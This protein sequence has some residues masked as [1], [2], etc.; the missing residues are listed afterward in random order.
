MASLST[1]I[2]NDNEEIK[3]SIPIPTDKT[4]LPINGDN[5]WENAFTYSIKYSTYTYSGTEAVV[6]NTSIITINGTI[7]DITY[8]STPTPNLVFNLGTPLKGIQY[9]SYAAITITV[10]DDA[11]GSVSFSPVNCIV[12]RSKSVSPY[13]LSSSWNEGKLICEFVLDELMT[14]LPIR[15]NIDLNYLNAMYFLPESSDPDTDIK[16]LHYVIEF[17]GIT[18][19]NGSNKKDIYFWNHNNALDTVVRN[20]NIANTTTT[21]AQKDNNDNTPD[22]ILIE[23]VSIYQGRGLHFKA[24]IKE[25]VLSNISI[26]TGGLL[27]IKMTVAY[28]QV[29]QD[30]DT[31]V[32][33]TTSINIPPDIKILYLRQRNVTAT[34]PT[35]LT[36]SDKS[37]LTVGNVFN[38][39]NITDNIALINLNAAMDN[40]IPNIGFYNT[41]QEKYFDLFIDTSENDAWYTLIHTGENIISGE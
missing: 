32:T 9:D 21:T 28:G 39:P 26:A 35:G 11:S 41:S 1:R 22:D 15:G 16:K 31:L 25:S 18:T 38:N 37:S 33:S 3:L 27:S 23:E 8:E 5:I 29:I 36:L 34:A 30:T 7:T 12:V 20:I 6:D 40:Q 17:S 24:E 4:R 10:L 14:P 2:F 19:T 13:L